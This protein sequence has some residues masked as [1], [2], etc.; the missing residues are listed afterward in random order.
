M[1]SRGSQLGLGHRTSAFWVGCGLRRS[2]WFSFSPG[3]NMRD[4]PFDPNILNS[5]QVTAADPGA[6][7]YGLSWKPVPAS[8]DRTR[9]QALLCGSMRS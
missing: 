7:G 9:G 4:V 8:T 5:S 1:S 3:A 2:V 6:A